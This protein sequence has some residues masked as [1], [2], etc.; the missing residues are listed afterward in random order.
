MK[1]S[2]FVFLMF[3]F[4]QCCSLQELLHSSRKLSLQLLNFIA[5]HQVGWQSSTT[6]LLLPIFY[7]QSSTTNLLLPIFYYQSSTTNLLL[8]YTTNHLLP[9]IYYQSS[10]TNLLLPIFYYQSSTTNLLLPIIYYQSS[11]TNLLLPIYQFFTTN[12]L[13]YTTNHLLPIFYHYRNLQHNFMY[14]AQTYRKYIPGEFVPH[15]KT[16]FRKTCEYIVVSVICQAVSLTVNQIFR[17]IP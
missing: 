10:T 6:N 15:L 17:G 1:C 2:S 11:T 7:Y 9:I 14:L 12:L 13:Q 8:Q 4:S 3:I 5:E 16:F